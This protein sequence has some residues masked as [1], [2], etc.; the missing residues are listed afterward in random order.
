MPITDRRTLLQAA[1]ALPLATA[2]STM[3]LADAAPAP[4]AAPA[5]P[6]PAK[7]VTRAL[8][9]YLVTAGYDDLPADVRK[10]GV[11]TLLNWVGV[12]I[13]GSRHQTVDIAVAALAPFSGPQQASLFGRR[14]RFDIMNAAFINGVSSHIFDYDDTHLKTIIHPAGP[15]ASA[16]LALSEMQPVSGKDFLN[17]LVLGVETECRIGN[18][19]YPNHYDVGWHIT[20]TAG[21]FGSAAAVGKL[22]KLNEQ[23][24]VW[25]LGLAASQP[26]GLRES[27]GSMNK[28][29][30][31]GRAASNGI[32]A[33]MLASKN[34][35][36]SDEMIEAKRGWANTIST[37][38][39]Y[40]EILGDLGKRYEAALNTYK[41][42][43]CGIVM[44]PAIDAAIQLRA[45]NMI[46]PDQIDH[47][48]LKVHPLVLELTGKK[49]PHEGLEGKF[50]IYHAVAVALVDGAGGE[51]QFS[52]RAVNDPTI[53]ALRGKVNPVI[54]PGIKPEQVDMTVVLGDGRQLHR[55]IEH[56]VGSVEVPMTDK[57]L[58]VKFTDLADGILPA[59]AIR[60]VMDACWNVEGL[61]DAAEIAK[62]SASA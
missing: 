51:K 33:A 32:F 42:F 41:P 31:P 46:T 23:Q 39:D 6:A 47:V 1:A 7:G 5:K 49:T 40:N 13:G 3:A 62:M 18:S 48:D 11:R 34:F 59:P 2:G 56:A 22:L 9:H 50:S 38:Q 16:I 43:A 35:T 17:A 15:V 12:A 61:S 14:E 57:Q 58:E 29:F 36:S 27:F 45:A 28:S 8:A 4:A 19:V 55:F 60:R 10:E 21:V 44:H 20:G 30:N 37:K 54:T 53:V 24:M 26:V 25:A 52:D